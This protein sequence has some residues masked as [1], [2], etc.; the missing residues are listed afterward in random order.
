[1]PLQ[2]LKDGTTPVSLSPKLNM[3][4]GILGNL[5]EEFVQIFSQFSGRKAVILGMILLFK[6]ESI[7]AGSKDFH[8]WLIKLP[9]EDLWIQISIILDKSSR[10]P[11]FPGNNYLGHFH[12]N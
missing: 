1:M 8:G 3:V 5:G 12:Q 4:S 2:N 10:S 6:D 9:D 11:K 7:Q